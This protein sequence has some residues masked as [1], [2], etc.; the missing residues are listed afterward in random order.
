MVEILGEKMRRS[1]GDGERGTLSRCF[2][3][4]KTNYD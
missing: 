2:T 1:G 3:H 4:G